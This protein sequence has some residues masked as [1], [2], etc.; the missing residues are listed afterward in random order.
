MQRLSCSYCNRRFSNISRW[1]CRRWWP[2]RRRRWR[3]CI[4]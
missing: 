2:R 1:W 4:L 3:Q